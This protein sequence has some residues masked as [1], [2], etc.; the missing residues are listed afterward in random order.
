MSIFCIFVSHPPA[1]LSH[2]YFDNDCKKLF[3]DLYRFPPNIPHFSISLSSLSHSLYRCLA[4]IP[5]D[6]ERQEQIWRDLNF[7]S[8]T[9]KYSKSINNPQTKLHCSTCN[10]QCSA[11]IF[12]SFPRRLPRSPRGISPNSRLS[13]ISRRHIFSCRPR[14]RRELLKNIEC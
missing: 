6:P 10:G 8:K 2:I 11:R 5:T 3:C 12:W 7:Y 9:K 14:H 1:N 13:A 4:T